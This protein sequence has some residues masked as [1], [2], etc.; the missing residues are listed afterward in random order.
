MLAAPIQ[1]Q[2]DTI[3]HTAVFAV[4]LIDPVTL[5]VVSGS[6]ITVTAAFAQRG[7]WNK[8]LSRGSRFAWMVDSSPATPVAGVV[9]TSV[10]VTP[11]AG[12]GYAPFTY[13]AAEITAGISA[14]ASEW[15]L[16]RLYLRT[17]SIYPFPGGITQVRGLLRKVPDVQG[18][19]VQVLAG[20]QV[21]LEWQDAS[22]NPPVARA[23]SRCLTGAAGDFAASLVFPS[24]ASKSY[25]AV[26]AATG[27]L[28]LTFYAAQ[29]DPVAG[30][31]QAHLVPAQN[32]PN[33][34]GTV[35]AGQVT[36]L[37]APVAWS[38]LTAG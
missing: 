16:C 22:A 26:T 25:P 20:A 21:W 8:A 5:Q 18:Q 32:Q 2:A 28:T 34:L 10:T 38:N 9:P 12:S 11:P 4:E 30:W 17:T 13:L 15:G 27:A 24:K 37:A 33:P 3:E 35:L 1:F 29:L 6:G 7:L 36:T 19:P 23:G 14:V 31:E